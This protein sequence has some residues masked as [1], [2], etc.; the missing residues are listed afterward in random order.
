M[1]PKPSRVRRKAN[2]A[3]NKRERRARRKTNGKWPLRDAKYLAWIRKLPCVCCWPK[4]WRS[5]EIPEL[6]ERG[7]KFRDRGKDSPSE[8]AHVG[9]RGMGQKCSDRETIPLCSTHHRLGRDAV[10]RIGWRFWRYHALD[11]DALI[12][13]LNQLYGKEKK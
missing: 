1:T 10:H 7:W 5:G 4:T 13:E 6:L 9:E 3:A 11:R 2:E 8:A 12:A